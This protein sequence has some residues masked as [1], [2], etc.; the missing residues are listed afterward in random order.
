MDEFYIQGETPPS[1]NKGGEPLKKALSV[2][3]Y[4]HSHIHGH[5]CTHVD[6][7]AKKHKHYTYVPHTQENLF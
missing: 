2:D 3:L 1:Q 6:N 5:T 4:R 7:H